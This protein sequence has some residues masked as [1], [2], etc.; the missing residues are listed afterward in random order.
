MT[1]E[2]QSRKLHIGAGRVHL[3]GWINIDLFDTHHQDLYCDLTRL[4]WDPC[5]FDEI[6]C[7]HVLEHCHRR[8]IAATIYH[9]VQMLRAGGKLRLAVPNF[10]AVCE[11]Y[12]DTGDLPELLGLLYGRQ[13]H[14][15]NNHFIVFDFNTLKRHMEL[16]GLYNV[17]RWDWRETE[18]A[19]FDDFS[20]CYLPHMDKVHGLLMSLN[21]Q[22]TKT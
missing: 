2:P 7:C 19:H 4:P 8:M 13:D 15:K 20:S 22:G 14:P 10:D 21:L 18:Q 1:P 17:Q 9:W 6:Y 11:R 3:P 5:S 12:A 16:A